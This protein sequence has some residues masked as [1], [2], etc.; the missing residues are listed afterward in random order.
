MK[1]SHV[2][3]F[4]AVPEWADSYINYTNLKKLLYSIERDII[5]KKAPPLEASRPDESR[6]LLTHSEEAEAISSFVA[7]L[8]HELDI[9][10]AFYRRKERELFAQVDLLE[11]E[12][13]KRLYRGRRF[14]GF[15]SSS[16]SPDS[17]R[18]YHNN[19]NNNNV[20]NS[21]ASI[22]TT[23]TTNQDDIPTASDHQQRPK[24][25]CHPSTRAANGNG[26]SYSHSYGQSPFST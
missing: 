21:D 8:D 14:R 20:N 18:R 9:I 2:I 5:V 17:Y 7:A 23:T 26:G 16:N 1:F 6:L 3:Q 10:E 13:S 22:R 15:G 24:H 12:A 19:N 25:T 11:R 4:N